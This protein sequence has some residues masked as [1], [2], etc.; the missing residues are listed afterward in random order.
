[1]KMSYMKALAL[2]RSMNTHFKEPLIA[3]SRGGKRGGGAQVTDA[4]RVVLAEYPAMRADTE[5]AAE[6]AWERIRRL[7]KK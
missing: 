2:V 3:L 6:P 7:L 1:M 4:G 5:S